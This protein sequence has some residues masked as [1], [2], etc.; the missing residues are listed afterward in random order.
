MSPFWEDLPER[1][2]PSFSLIGGRSR[3]GEVSPARV[4]DVSS[5]SAVGGSV[6]EIELHLDVL[7]N[8]EL[9]RAAVW[10]RG[11]GASLGVFLHISVPFLESLGE[12]K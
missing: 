9:T 12:K 11:G 3:T 10:K 4:A 1:T 5:V 8:S 7:G 2:L 6:C